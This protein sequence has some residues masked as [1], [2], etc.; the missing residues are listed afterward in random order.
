MFFLK[1]AF[2][3]PFT[4]GIFFLF[5]CKNQQPEKSSSKGLL[6]WFQRKPA[7]SAQ[8][9][10]VTQMLKIPDCLEPDKPGFLKYRFFRLDDYSE[11]K[12]MKFLICL[13]DLEKVSYQKVKA[14]QLYFEVTLGDLLERKTLENL[15]GS[16]SQNA[17][18]EEKLP[19]IPQSISTQLYLQDGRMIMVHYSMEPDIGFTGKNICEMKLSTLKLNFKNPIVENGGFFGFSAEKLMSLLSHFEQQ[20][21]A[22]VV[23]TFLTN[24]VLKQ[25]QKH[26][27]CKTAEKAEISRIEMSLESKKFRFEWLEDKSYILEDKIKELD[28]Q[29]RSGIAPEN[30]RR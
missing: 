16:Q 19:K 1:S 9:K 13:R 7:S 23:G 25:A 20:G 5:G 18:V 3:L 24:V 2:A 26:A 10:E 4:F 8:G 12:Q 27:L 6:D 22:Q 30:P 29:V 14:L 15:G 17:A 11:Q 21:A 28:E